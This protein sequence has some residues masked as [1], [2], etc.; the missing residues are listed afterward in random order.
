MAFLT[1]GIQNLP[2]KYGS[3]LDQ[4]A[5]SDLVNKLG[6][7]LEA[8][9]Q[10]DNNQK[11]AVLTGAE[12]GGFIR[13]YELASSDGW[14]FTST[15]RNIHQDLFSLI[16]QFEPTNQEHDPA[17]IPL[18]LEIHQLRKLVREFGASLEQLQKLTSAQVA[19][20]GVRLQYAGFL[21]S[22]HMQEIFR[23]S[24]AASLVNYSANAM[25]PTPSPLVSPCPSSIDTPATSENPNSGTSQWMY[26]GS[27]EGRQVDCGTETPQRGCMSLA[28]PIDAI[29]QSDMGIESPTIMS[30]PG[31][32]IAVS[33]YPTPLTQ[34][35][36]PGESAF[37]VPDS[38]PQPHS[39]EVT[40]AGDFAP[41]IEGVY[42]T[43]STIHVETPRRKE[44]PTTPGVQT[45]MVSHGADAT[46]LNMFPGKQATAVKIAEDA[47]EV[48]L[49][50]LQS[51]SVSLGN[52]RIRKI[53][54]AEGHLLAQDLDGMLKPMF[55]YWDEY[56][57]LDLHALGLPVQWN[58]IQAAVDYL[59]VLDADAKHPYLIPIAKNIGQVLLYFNYEELCRNPEKYCPPSQDKFNASY[60]LKCILNAYP[61]DPRISDSPQSRRDRITTYHVRRGRWCWRLAG[62][63]GGGIL[64]AS[65]PLLMNTMY[66]YT[67]TDPQIKVFITFVQKVRPGTIRVFKALEPV[68]QSLMFSK[69][70]YDLRKAVFDRDFGLL[71]QDEMESVRVDD[72]NALASLRFEHSW[73]VVDAENVARR[74]KAEFFSEHIGNV[75]LH[76]QPT[77]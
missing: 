42:Q 4:D 52:D 14:T 67:F 13:W 21:R 22:F 61:D 41:E 65:H 38:N 1:V 63:L 60:V 31:T 74:R 53:L 17:M 25:Q 44:Q 29:L 56:G 6:K 34:C 33:F 62:N 19:A 47:N 68:V 46:G 39:R 36:T 32:E 11:T 70:T 43:P 77:P 49:E 51:C 71:R 10:I 27:N 12:G 69:I 54:G 45:T 15:L 73:E 5:C 64:L 16:F 8:I 48:A 37:L 28:D 50:M 72:Q 55:D 2:R 7:E 26:S 40:L 66:N 20:I 57:S 9:G 59:R 35:Q 3:E 18:I 23:G 76:S 30:T 75:E 24:L 58:G